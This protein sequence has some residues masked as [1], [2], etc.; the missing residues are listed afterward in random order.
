MYAASRRAPPGTAPGAWR[1]PR[2]AAR[3][4]RT[5]RRRGSCPRAGTCPVSQ[6]AIA[7]SSQCTMLIPPCS[8]TSHIG[9]V[10]APVVGHPAVGGQ[11]LDRRHAATDDV[12][13]LL[14]VLEREVTRERG[15]QRP[16]DGHPPLELLAPARQRVERPE[17]LLEGEVDHRRRAA[18][19]GGARVLGALRGE[20]A[21]EVELVVHVRVDPAGDHQAA[22][23]IDHAL[24]RPPSPGSCRPVIFSPSIDTSSLLS[25]CAETT[26]PPLISTSCTPPPFSFHRPFESRRTEPCQRIGLFV[27]KHLAGKPDHPGWAPGSH[28]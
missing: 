1:P 20:H 22:A 4:S 14:D 17:L 18:V 6:F 7:S 15:V 23:R 12:A 3:A 9:A 27:L 25:P 28:R 19:H 10:A 11:R 26:V 8:A 2:R 21:L 5:R 16:V 24:C 13:D